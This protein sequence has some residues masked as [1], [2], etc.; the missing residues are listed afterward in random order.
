LE[1]I[2]L[3][4]SAFGLANVSVVATGAPPAVICSTPLNLASSSGAAVGTVNAKV[5]NSSGEAL[6]VVWLVDGI[7]RQTNFTSQAGGPVHTNVSL[8]AQFTTGEHLVTVSAS[9]GHTSPYTCSTTVT[10]YPCP[11]PNLVVNGSFENGFQRWIGTFGLYQTPNPVSGRTVGVVIDI[12]SSSINQCLSQTIATA[13][14]T[15]YQ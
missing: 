1:F 6:T 15:T 5:Q 11:L 8:T 7:P 3:N 2:D 10:V 13:P 12:W 14:G 4:T 9:D